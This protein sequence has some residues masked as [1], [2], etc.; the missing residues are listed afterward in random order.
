MAYITVGTGVGV[1]LIVD[2]KC[3]HGLTHPDGGHIS[4]KPA[5]G[6]TF[7]GNL[8]LNIQQIFI[9]ILNKYFKN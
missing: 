7:K 5:P 9:E 2:G 1:G 4:V 6:D 3:V 8:C